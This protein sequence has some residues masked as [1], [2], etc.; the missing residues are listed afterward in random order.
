ML[1][2]VPVHSE[3]AP[4]AHANPSLPYVAMRFYAAERKEN[5][6]LILPHS[7]Q[8][9]GQSLKTCQVS[10]PAVRPERC[11]GYSFKGKLT[12]TYGMVSAERMRTLY[13]IDSMKASHGRIMHRVLGLLLRGLCAATFRGIPILCPVSSKICPD[14]YPKP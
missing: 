1:E 10:A 7:E 3:T 4:E 5:T 11:S 13:Q 12:A 14:G 9:V 6:K 8:E 2:P